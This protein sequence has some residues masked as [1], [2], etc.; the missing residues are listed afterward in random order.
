[1]KPNDSNVAQKSI[2]KQA[3]LELTCQS[4]GQDI[5]A[6]Y[7]DLHLPL[8][9]ESWT[10]QD[11]PHCLPLKEMRTMRAEQVLEK[12]SACA[13]TIKNLD[14]VV[15]ANLEERKLDEIRARQEY[16]ATCLL[17]LNRSQR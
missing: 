16:R 3:P 14:A 7:N 10:G 4:C 8:V 9:W 13:E 12:C 5:V 1:M 11:G 17:E 6:L 15:C 2:E